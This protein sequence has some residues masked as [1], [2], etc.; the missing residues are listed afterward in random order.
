MTSSFVYIPVHTDE[1]RAAI[2]WGSIAKTPNEYAFKDFKNKAI[3]TGTISDLV[4]VDIDLGGL[5]AWNQYVAEHG[6]PMTV[7]VSTPSGGFHYYFKYTNVLSGSRVKVAGV[8][9]DIRS[10]RAYIVCPPSKIGKKE[11]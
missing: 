10:N 6:E 2:N 9:I 7:K 3:L 4:V 1:K 5:A 11:Y 8:G